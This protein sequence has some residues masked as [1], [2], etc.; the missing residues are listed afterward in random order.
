[1]TSLIITQILNGLTIGLI[2]ALVAIGLT[3]VMGLMEVVNF[4][5]G[6]FYMF[7][8]YITF[9]VFS[10]VGSFW[11]GLVVA[12]VACAIL[13]LGLYYAIIR[14]L[15]K[16]HP[17]EPLVA[18]VGVAMICR[19]LIRNIWGAEP[20]L[21]PIPFGRVQVSLAGAEFT[22]P[23]YF[24][25]VMGVG[26]AA[27]L[28]LYLLFRKSDVG[29]RCL[30]A[31]Q[32]RDTAMSMGVNVD[33]IGSLMLVIVMGVAGLAGGLVGPIFSVYPT[34]G[35]ELI[36]LL[37]VIAIVGGLGSIGGAVIAGVTIAMTKSISSI[38]VSGNISDILAYC[39]L[40][41][42]LLIRPRGIMGLATVME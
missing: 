7:G 10:A 36:G 37:F 18:L 28:A 4:A 2:F 6:S 16:R 33:R 26:V 14:P 25:V 8:G 39:V 22:Y 31:I 15:R 19:Q 40:L 17:L 32:D 23:I 11:L 13:G 35:L 38:F 29:I 30:A 21:L 42:I 12:P 3:I 5:H 20:K 41:A 24:F 27:L 9:F 34:M 1:M